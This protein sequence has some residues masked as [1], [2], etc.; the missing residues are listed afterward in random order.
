MAELVGCLGKAVEE[1]DRALVVGGGWKRLVQVG[2]TERRGALRRDGD[3][4]VMRCHGGML[5]T[6]WVGMGE[7][8]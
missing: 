4:A 1:E 3:G 5:S 2:K 6:R 8:L 7:V